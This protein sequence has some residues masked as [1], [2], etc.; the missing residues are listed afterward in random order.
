MWPQHVQQYLPEIE[1]LYSGSPLVLQ[2]WEKSFPEK[3]TVQ[4]QK[5]VDISGTKIRNLCLN[6]EKIV[7]KKYLLDSTISLLDT[8]K[9]QKRLKN[10]KTY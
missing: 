6:D 1:T 7:L 3:N 4:I 5:R 9:I 10:M 2:L 8:F